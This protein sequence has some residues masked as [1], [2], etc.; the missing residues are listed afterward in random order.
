MKKLR[1]AVVGAGRLGGFHAQKLAANETVDLVAVADPMAAQRNR[2]AAECRTEAVADPKELF[3]RVDAVVIAAPTQLHY[4]L[5]LQ[6]LREGIHVLMEKPLCASAAH[7]EELVETA[8]SRGTLLQVGHVERFNPAF[9]AAASHVRDAKYVEAVRASGFTFRSTDVGVVLDLMIHDLDL[10][11]SL[12]RSPVRRVE[13]MGLSVLGGH[14]DVANVRLEFENGCIAALSASR[15]SYEAARRMHV[16][17]PRCFASIDFAARSTTL[18]EPSEILLRRQFD[19]DALSPEQVAH[20]KDHIFDELLPRTQKSFDAVD[21]L[22][23]E[24]HDFLD[25]IRAPRAPRVS[26]QQGCDAVRLAEQILTAI[27]EHSWDRRAG[28]LVG[29]LAIPRPSAVPAPHF[30]RTPAE[31]P[32]QRR[33]AG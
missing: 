30:E 17:A 11:L 5:G 8:R 26:G 25:S 24:Q 27:D 21:A 31:F 12:V 32:L 7:A 6:F 13:A 22:A 29:P 10:V 14:E 19:V 20:Y 2:V 4:E 33:Q 23:L 15:V 3:G 16:W 28:G 9:N 1:L 18:V